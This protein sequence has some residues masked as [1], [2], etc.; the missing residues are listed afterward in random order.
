MRRQVAGCDRPSLRPS[1][2][3]LWVASGTSAR[4]RLRSIVV[5]LDHSGSTSSDLI[6]ATCI[7]ASISAIWG[8]VRIGC[9][10]S[11]DNAPCPARSPT[12]ARRRG[13]EMSGS[14]YLGHI[15]RGVHE[16]VKGARLCLVQRDAQG[17]LDLVAKRAPVDHRTVAPDDALCLIRSSRRAQVA[18]CHA[19]KIGQ[20]RRA[21]RGRAGNG[22]VCAGLCRRA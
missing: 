3:A 6:R 14:R 8:R 18:R 16:L 7:S 5:E 20:I 1:A 21:G 17:D 12:G 2:P 9:D 19:R 13:P 4:S 10:R 11:A 22:A 15:A